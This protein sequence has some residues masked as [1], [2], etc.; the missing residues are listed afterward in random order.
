MYHQNPMDF[1]EWLDARLKEKGWSR[2]EAA[3]RGDISASMFDKVINRHAKPGLKFIEGVARAFKIDVA[4]VMKYVND[5]SAISDEITRLSIDIIGNFKQEET[6]RKA[7][8]QLKRLADQETKGSNH[9]APS[10]KRSVS[11]KT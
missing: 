11:V 3:R 4:D 8:A 10:P 6:K 9:G 7:Y 2:S 1:S 5:S